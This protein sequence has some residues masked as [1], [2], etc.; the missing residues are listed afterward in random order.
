MIL[1]GGNLFFSDVSAEKLFNVVTSDPSEDKRAVAFVDTVTDKD[2]IVEVNMS[3][4]VVWE[5]EFPIELKGKR[6][7]SICAAAD[8]N[9]IKARDELLF[10]VPQKGAYIVN[11]KGKYKTVIEDSEITHDIDQLPN[12]NFI[13][14]RGFVNKGDDEVREVTPTGKIVWKWSHAD[15]FPDRDKYLTN[16]PEGMKDNWRGRHRVLRTDGID[17]A[18]VNA[19]ERYKNG[20]T[21]ISLRNFLMFV[22]VD[23]KGYPKKLHKDIWLVHEPHKTNFGFIA[24]DR[25]SGRGAVQF[26]IVKI[27][28]NGK[29]EDLLTRDFFAVRGIEVL[30][31][32]RFN[33]TSVGNVFEMDA[34]GKIVRR[35]HLTIQ[36]EDSENNLGADKRPGRVLVEGRCAPKN[37]YKV[38]KTKIY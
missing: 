27:L 23:P 18:H 17:W 1:G 6:K 10:V 3:G 13:Y 36:D 16:V 8:I 31:S 12:G 32:G 30:P 2:R 28:K 9:Y 11:R 19:V 29:R 33:I 4:E 20:D 37:L 15:H 5:W 25:F 38:V 35:M 24:S 14:T 7:K 21:L 22:I 26:S 34:A